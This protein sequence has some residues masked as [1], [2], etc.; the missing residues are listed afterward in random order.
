MP[1][2]GTST[3]TANAATAASLAFHYS[4]LL[5]SNNCNSNLNHLSDLAKTSSSLLYTNQ[6]SLSN[7]RINQNIL[8]EEVNPSKQQQ[9]FNDNSK[10]Q[11]GTFIYLF[12]CLLNQKKKRKE[13]NLKVLNNILKIN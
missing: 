4:Q 11:K 12:I 13:I 5:Q 10:S 8:S 3:A 2:M 6:D 1:M 7:K 9:N